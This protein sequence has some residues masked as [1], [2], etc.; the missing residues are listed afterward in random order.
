MARLFPQRGFYQNSGVGITFSGG[1]PLAQAEF[2]FA[3]AS[4]MSSMRWQSTTCHNDRRELRIMLLIPFVRSSVE[5][6]IKVLSS[7]AHPMI[8]R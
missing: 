4:F 8:T 1:E 5:A 6:D 7:Y 3:L 2:A